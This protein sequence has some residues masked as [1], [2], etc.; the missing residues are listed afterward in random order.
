[1]KKTLWRA[2]NDDYV[3]TGYSFAESRWISELYMDIPGFGGSHLYRCK[4]TVDP[5]TVLDLT[6]SSAS[7]VAESLG[8]YDPGAI[9]L[10]EWIPRSPAVM[11]ALREQGY[12]WALVLESYPENTT[13]WI[14]I[15]TFDD[16]EPE[17][18]LVES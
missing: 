11:D 18:E 2:A 10:E 14:W 12:L 16:D 1:M 8:T 9:G 13:T 15:G 5:E 7:E 6:K 17:L 4:V 3:N